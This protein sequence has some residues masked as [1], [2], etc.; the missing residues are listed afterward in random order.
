MRTS[1]I[2][3]AWAPRDPDPNSQGRK[4]DG[5][6][7]R[8]RDMPIPDED[9]PF[10]RL[11]LDKADPGDQTSVLDIG[12]GA[13]TFSLPLA[14]RAGSVLG[15]DVSERMVGF[16]NSKASAMGMSNA[17]YRVFD[18]LS[19]PVSS[20]GDGFDLVLAHM[21][22]AISSYDSFMKM[23]GLVRGWCFVTRTVSR[24]DQVRRAVCRDLG[25][26]MPDAARDMA[27]MTNLLWNMGHAP[28]VMHERRPY[29]MVRD[30]SELSS[31][32]CAEFRDQ[33]DRAGLSDEDVRCT[34]SRFSED[35]KIKLE[36]I[37]TVATLCF[38]RRDIH[39]GR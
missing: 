25:L 10:I 18:W 5:M 8:F 6:A 15:L 7:D 28:C 12:C 29:D 33:I 22:P 11:V 17:E 9:D 39:D 24:G 37:W 38:D 4:W 13:G 1:Q 21:T 35:G 3:E 2:R 20:L 31:E 26:E 27:F 16:A 14:G 30:E 32:Y 34:V 19:E 36:G 23:Y